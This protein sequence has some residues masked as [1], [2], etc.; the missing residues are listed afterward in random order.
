MIPPVSTGPVGQ[1]SC[2]F[3]GYVIPDAGLGH[4][5]PI[6]SACSF[7]S[8]NSI[9]AQYPQLLAGR[10]HSLPL[11]LKFQRLRFLLFLREQFPSRVN[12]PMSH[13]PMS[14]EAQHSWDFRMEQMMLDDS[15]SSIPGDDLTLLPFLD[16]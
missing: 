11:F 8:F 4:A 3:N 15:Y 13:V 2:V 16:C 14:G 9:I 12:G 6:S 5:L 7:T 10:I 1:G